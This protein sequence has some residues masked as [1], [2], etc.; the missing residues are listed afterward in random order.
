MCLYIMAM[1]Y[2]KELGFFTAISFWVTFF[3][4]HQKEKDGKKHIYKHKTKPPKINVWFNV[5]IRP[6]PNPPLIPL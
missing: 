4:T 5:E 1:P 6:S 2:K 3:H